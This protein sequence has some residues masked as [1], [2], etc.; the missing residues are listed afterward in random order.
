M[1]IEKMNITLPFLDNLITEWHMSALREQDK[2]FEY[3]LRYLIP[4]PIK[5]EITKG[6]IK[7]RGIYLMKPYEEPPKLIEKDGGFRVECKF[8]FP[9]LCGKPSKSGKRPEFSINLGFQEPIL[10]NYH[11]YK[12]GTHPMNILKPDN[13]RISY[14]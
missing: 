8:L 10:S 4:Q 2:R 1:E 7:W 3:A 12:I 9:I 14:E 13:E 11:L 6:K 5:G